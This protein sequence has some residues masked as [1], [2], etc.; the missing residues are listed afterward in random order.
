MHYAKKEVI[1]PER[2]RLVLYAVIRSGREYAAKRKYRVPL[3]YQ[4]HETEYLGA[5]HGLAGILQMLMRYSYISGAQ[6][7]KSDNPF[8]RKIY[9]F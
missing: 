7:V 5:A 1:I 6:G 4:Y 8:H 9:E 2:L 3:M